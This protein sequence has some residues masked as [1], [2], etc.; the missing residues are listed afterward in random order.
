MGIRE[1][2]RS[3]FI[4]ESGTA[5]VETGKKYAVSLDNSLESGHN[6]CNRFKVYKN[7]YMKVPLVTSIIDTQAD[8]TV[9]E[10]FFDGP[11]KEKLTKWSDKVNLPDFFHKITKSMLIYGNAY[12]ELVKEGEEI[13]EL[14]PLNPIWIDVYREP[15]GDVIGYSQIIGDE[16]KVL[17]GST[18]D[19][20]V[21]KSFKKWLPG[22]LDTIVHF[23]HNVISSEKY[24]MSIIE[25]MVD[26]LNAKLDMES[27]L[28]KVLFKYVAPL[29]WAKVGNDDFP[30]NQA[31]ITDI[32]NTL[33]DLQAES[34]LTTSHLV[35]LQVLDF[36]SK[37]MDIKTPVEQIEQ[38]IVTGGQVPPVLLGRSAGVDK[39]TAEVQLRNFGR[40]IKANQRELKNQFEDN[41]IV[42][43][44]LGNEE[45][46]L[47]WT[48]AEEREREVEI[49]MLRGLV[50]DGIITPQKANDL[51]PPK[52]QEELPDP[53]ER[54]AEMAAATGAN[55]GPPG[56]SGPRPTQRKDKK[57]KDNPNDPTQT[58][59][60]PRTLGK[61]ANKTDREVP[62]K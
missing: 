2:I 60:N 32:A 33:R 47:V 53:I 26:A 34:E 19:R 30:A 58:T 14:K 55:Q 35:D 38:Q 44:A 56:A 36:N 9:Q 18:G 62:V 51:L 29:I 15:T 23:K 43:Q 6:R 49:D 25:P 1:S 7:A 28:S 42:K 31:A 16:K 40:H 12:V 54:A 57:V 45:D 22:K 39:A 24:G 5:I 27:N 41:I 8:Q 13:S 3:Y 50:T 52:F 21:D 61:R 17:W 11:N 37:G 20:D 10:F 48:Q 46:K 59:K 4:K